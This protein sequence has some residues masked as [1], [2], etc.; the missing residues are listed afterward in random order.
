VPARK[1]PFF[2]GAPAGFPH[3]RASVPMKSASS[4]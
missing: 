4:L 3:L 2:K 1:C